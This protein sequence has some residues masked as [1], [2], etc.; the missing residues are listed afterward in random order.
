L[1]SSKFKVTEVTTIK[2]FEDI[3]AWQKA[4]ILNKE[5]YTISS[6][7]K[8]SN[9]Y[10]LKDQMRRASVSITSNIAEG[11]EREG[12]QEFIHFLSI[13]KGSC[14]E[15]RSQLYIAFDLEYIS[16]TEFQQLIQ[17]LIQVSKTIGGLM[18]YLKSY[19]YKGTKYKVEEPMEIYQILS[20]T[21]DLSSIEL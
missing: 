12:K 9:D 8:L 14:G 11:F 6:K 4:R 5:I 21:T 2:S 10:S 19:E 20:K 15:L 16:E 13:A 17:N 1:E 3:I 7:G 18:N